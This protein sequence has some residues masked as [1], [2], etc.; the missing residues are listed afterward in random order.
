MP[1]NNLKPCPICGGDAA[2]GGTYE[3]DMSSRKTTSSINCMSCGLNIRYLPTDAAA[4]GAWNKRTASAE[5]K[6]IFLCP[7]CGESPELHIKY[8]NFAR[9]HGH[10]INGKKIKSSFHLKCKC[11]LSNDV[12]GVGSETKELAIA[13]WNRRAN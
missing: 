5:T 1:A 7:M 3:T 2:I 12:M 4:I 6:A 9:H 11:G 8:H 10:Y 13:K